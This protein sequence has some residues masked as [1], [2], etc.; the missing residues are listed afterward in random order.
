VL[1]DELRAFAVATSRARRRLVVTAV[2]DAEDAPSV[3][4]DLVS[5]P[6]GGTTGAEGADP[7]RATVGPP[8]DLRGVVAEARATLVRAAD[9]RDAG[10][11]A[12]GPV[13]AAAALLAGLAGAGIAE[14]DPRTWYGVAATSSE[15][16]LWGPDDVVTVS[17]SKVETVS[18]C[19]LKWAFE[20]A[21]ATAPDA[22]HQTLGTLVHEIAE[23]LPQASL[24]ALRAELDRRW[25][26]LALPDGWPARQL[27]NRAEQ[28]IE[29]LAAYYTEAGEPVLVEPEFELT[30]GRARL[31]GKIDRVEDAGDE[32]VTV[33]DLKTGRTAPAR[34]KATEHPQ[35]GAYQLAVAEGALDL[36]PGTP[37]AGARLVYVGTP[38]VAPT[39]RSQPALDV[40]EDGSSWARALVESAADTMAASRFTAH[41]NDLCPMCPVRRSCPVQP[42]GRNVIG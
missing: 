19:A 17:P 14:A 33:A 39:L 34:A 7:R 25:P 24:T 28:M 41:E 9:R 16:P 38:T 31:R 32:G 5:P 13:G 37:S 29:R 2:E 12:D 18:T 4:L 20:S 36:P 42:E 30:V 10:G 8:L 1:A 11:D 27:R 15:A 6:D 22:T 23:T 35:L 3:F 26:E 21:G 40:G